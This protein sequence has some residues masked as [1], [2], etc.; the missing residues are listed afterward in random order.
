MA[1]EWSCADMTGAS[2]RYLLTLHT[3]AKV[4]VVDGHG[5]Q[6]VLGSRERVHERYRVGDWSVEATFPQ[7]D[8]IALLLV[9]AQGAPKIDLVFQE[10]RI[11]GVDIEAWG[12]SQHA[13]SFSDVRSVT[14]APGNK[15]VVDGQGDPINPVV[16][17]MPSEEVEA[18]RAELEQAR[19][20]RDDLQ[21][22]LDASGTQA[23]D[24]ERRATE[25]EEQAREA[26]RQLQEQRARADALRNA[27]EGR[28]ADMLAHAQAE[29]AVLDPDLQ[30]LVDAIAQQ[31]AEADGISAQISDAQ[32]RQEE[33]RGEIERLTQERDEIMQRV[34]EID[35][36]DCQRAREE[37][38][39]LRLRYEANEQTVD[40][41]RDDPFLTGNSVRRTLER[42]TDQLAAAEKRIGLIVA[43]RET[44]LHEVQQS[45]NM[46]GGVLPLSQELERGYDVDGDAEPAEEQD[47]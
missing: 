30:T 40:L 18:L 44:Y 12:D 38:E 9:P 42:V 28:L 41:M 29:R 47:S 11:R 8:A 46:G 37:V 17:G 34:E 4:A 26:Q 13:H 20:Q 39:E 22:Q 19:A 24:L 21:R 15:L 5:N 7:T 33:L 45:V 10:Q 3:A 27:A 16:Q 2:E 6:Q 36:L 43:Y 35:S 25:A 1:I 32:R 31:Q 14:I 23:G